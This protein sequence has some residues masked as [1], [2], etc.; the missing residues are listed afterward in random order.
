MFDWL[1]EALENSSEVITAN[2]RLAR[3]LER[4]YA[5][6]QVEAGLTAWRSPAIRSLQDWLIA[7]T[8]TTADPGR[9]MPTRLTTHQSRVLWER[10]LANNLSSS[11]VLS[12]A[13]LRQARDAWNRLRAGGVSLERLQESVRGFDQR[14]FANAARDYAA[15]LERENWVDAAGLAD[16]AT[17]LV[18]AGAADIPSRL[19]FAGFDRL[20]PAEERLREAL[21]AQGAEII[22]IEVSRAQG[23]P[24]LA[25]FENPDIELRAA[26]AWARDRL[27][28]DPGR[29]VAIVA[30]HLERDAASAARLIREGVA[31]GWQTGGADHKAAVN[32]SYGH[33]LSSYPAIAAALVALQWLHRDI[34]SAELSLLLRAPVIGRGSAGARARIELRL[35]DLP[36]MTWSPAA[37]ARVFRNRD[38]DQGEWQSCIQR[39]GARRAD[40]G[41][42][43]SPAEWA[44][45]IDEALADL[46]WP[47][48][49]TL[50]SD[51]F[52]LVNRW[53]E[54]LNELARLA[55]VAPGLDYRSA[56]TRLQVIAGET[57]FQPESDDTGVQVIGP[58]EAAGME[59]DCLWISGLSS[60]N[61]PPQGNPSVLLSR[62]LQREFEM[63]DFE[64]DDT[65]AYARRVLRRL[66]ASAG[67]VFCSY[68]MTDDDAEQT[69]S[70]L[71]HDLVEPAATPPADPGWYACEL[72]ASGQTAIIANDPVPPVRSDESVSGGTATIQ[73]Q[74]A[75]PFSAF[76]YGRLGIRPIPRI[77]YGVSASQRGRF[78]HAALARLY[79]AI[80]SQNELRQTA[81]ADLA[82]KRN[83]AARAA[84]AGLAARADT[85]MQRFLQL[86][87][88][89][90]ADLL[91][92]V[93]E[94][95]LE[96]AAFDVVGL[97]VPV[98]LSVG[99]VRMSLRA[100][101]VDR[102]PNGYSITKR[103]VVDAS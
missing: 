61:W 41:G 56:L 88:G 59:F 71:L 24:L 76:A 57:V 84:V 5:E 70:G 94:L 22:D 100:D 87:Q 25:G 49:G 96:R 91:Q 69:P 78:I 80:Q 21:R 2:R 44:V 36:A 32:V 68:P 75:E 40:L 93:V 50:S 51:E 55:L 26:G 85:V 8:D 28:E 98:D 23:R 74:L 4:R 79:S 101:R 81:P 30:L 64:P 92:G 72:A 6:Q 66:V 33:S 53:R 10:C 11:M 15:R 103:V 48:D 35:R 82:S 31:P 90:I 46:N 17:E 65:L 58:L 20:T 12:G 37:V 77:A 62:Q 73:R 54:L 9:S 38:G 97:E 42:K 29:R 16:L 45:A 47:G 27:L 43:R 13:L 86:E 19:V 83:D 60:A 1:T 18:L 39:F 3:F 52:Q 14:V 95:D 63:P 89:R 99:Q 102:E 7:S 67:E 34:S